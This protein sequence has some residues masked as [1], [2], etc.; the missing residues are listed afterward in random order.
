MGSSYASDL[1]SGRMPEQEAK[2]REAV[3][4]V[5]EVI[6]EWRDFDHD[7]FDNAAQDGEFR[8]DLGHAIRFIEDYLP[9][10]ARTAAHDLKLALGMIASGGLSV[11]R[12][13]VQ[14]ISSDES[15]RWWVSDGSVQGFGPD[16][17]AA[18]RAQRSLRAERGKRP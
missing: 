10:S 12:N 16:I 15:T 3:R 11:G 7:Q 5:R 6:A 9:D 1:G 8:A 14:A 18:L 17:P 4:L 2:L 13:A